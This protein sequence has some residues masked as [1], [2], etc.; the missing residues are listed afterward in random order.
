MNYPESIQPRYAAVRSEIAAG[1][2]TF[3]LLPSL[4][5]ETCV[6]ETVRRQIAR[7]FGRLREGGGG[8]P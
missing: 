7:P 3:V 5:F 1:L 2:T 8:H 6:K 4:D